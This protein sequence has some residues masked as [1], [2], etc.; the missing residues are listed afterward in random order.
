MEEQQL[1]QTFSENVIN[2]GLKTNKL[3]ELDIQIMK[4]QFSNETEKIKQ[5][6]EQYNKL[7]KETEELEEIC[8]TQYFLVNNS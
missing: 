7:D 6:T 5:L 3:I 4:L 8:V 2:L 1:F